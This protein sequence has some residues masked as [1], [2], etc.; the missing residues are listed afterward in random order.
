LSS[1]R[2][3]AI[4]FTSTK[5]IAYN[6]WAQDGTSNE[7]FQELLSTVHFRMVLCAW[8]LDFTEASAGTAFT[9]TPYH[10]EAAGACFNHT[11]TG[12]L[13]ESGFDS[14]VTAL[15]FGSI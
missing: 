11:P 9:D 6:K 2:R 8:I 1:L 14:S 10:T 12:W 15:L 13:C 4:Q 3:E 5:G 7:G